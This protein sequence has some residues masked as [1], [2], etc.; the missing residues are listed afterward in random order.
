MSLKNRYI[1]ALKG[2]Q[3][4]SDIKKDDICIIIDNL[5]DRC[6][7]V[8]PRSSETPWNIMYKDSAYWELLPED[9]TL[10]TKNSTEKLDDRKR[11][12]KTFLPDEWYENPLLSERI[13]NNAKYFKIKSCDQ[14]K[15]YNE[16]YW[17]N[18]ILYSHWADK[19]WNIHEFSY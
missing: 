12:L 1:K 19:D 16:T 10:P 2:G 14:F 11:P 13:E 4:S 18:E 5:G 17:Y 3:L 8:Y 6:K 7:V 9:Y 15:D